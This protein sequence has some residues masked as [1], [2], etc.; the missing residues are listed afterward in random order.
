M[1][2]LILV[3]MVASTA[4][5]SAMPVRHIATTTSSSLAASKAT[6]SSSSSPLS[7]NENVPQERRAFL[8][9]L[10]GAAFGASALALNS[11]SASASYSA[12]AAREKDWEERSKSGEINYSSS[13]DLKAQLR[14]IA[15]MNSSKSLMFCPNGPSSAVSPLMENK[16]DGDR[17]AIPSVFGRTEDIVGNSI[18]GFNGGKYEGSGSSSTSLAG[19]VGFPKY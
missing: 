7:E 18:P 9:N 14:E 13:R 4:A 17:Q 19:E 8:R 3:A 16:C 12:Y 2:A 11:D 5:F 6:S 15:P 1:V 10:A